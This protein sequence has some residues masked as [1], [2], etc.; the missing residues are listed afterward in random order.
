MRV[1]ITYCVTIQAMIVKHIESFDDSL[2]VA[3][4]AR[5]EEAEKGAQGGEIEVAGFDLEAVLALAGRLNEDLP[6][7]TGVDAE[8][9]DF[10]AGGV[11]SNG[12]AGTELEGI[13]LDG[14]RM[15]VALDPGE[16]HVIEI[17][18]IGREK[19]TGDFSRQRPRPA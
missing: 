7:G 3:S 6:G 17:V 18:T 2:A 4:V 16:S 9:K 1:T 13:A 14:C 12:R 8:V 5:V 15:P 11:A 19:T 10:G